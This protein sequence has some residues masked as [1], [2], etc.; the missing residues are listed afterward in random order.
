M[1]TSRAR[2]AL[3]L[4]AALL[5]PARALAQPAPAPTPPAAPAPG[6]PAPD[7]PGT[8][9]GWKSPARAAEPPILPPPSRP[10]PPTSSAGTDVAT[11]EPHAAATVILSD[12][13]SE[14]KEDARVRA[15][16]ARVSA[17]EQRIQ[18]LEGRLAFLKHLRLESFIQ[19][20]LLV[21][22]YN[23]AASPNLQPNGELPIGI[24]ANDTTAKL[25]G[26]TTNGT[27]FRVR[28]ARMRTFYETDVMKMFLQIDV[29]PA[30]GV[31]P[32]IGTILRNAE[33]SGIVRWSRDV[34]TELT[35][36]LFFTPFRAELLEASVNRPFIERTWFIQNV[37]PIER[38]YGAK[39]RTIAL[40]GDRLVVE[41]A[42][43]NGQRLGERNFVALP[44][45]NRSK[46]FIGYVTYRLG[47]VTVGASGYLGRGQLIDAEALRFKQYSR[48]AVNYQASAAYRLLGGIGE[49]RLSS[50][51][52]IARNMDAGV[53]YPFAVPAIP[54][55]FTDDVAHL[56]QR[57]LYVRA[58]QDIKRHVTLG[59]R[60]DMYTP[61]TA[62]KNNARDTHAF[63]A[64]WKVS[65]NLRFMSELGWAI[66]N[67]HPLGAPAPSKHIVYFS[68]VLQAMF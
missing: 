43:V 41:V 11:S 39:A 51:L 9:D 57:A 32:G 62:I 48:W 15:L 20:Q 21:Q 13:E 68:N 18:K 55:R 67:V 65:P 63:L 1:S 64:V 14:A 38:D 25:D 35:A 22:S 36:G 5:A 59:Y 33:A 24:G 12:R 27:F 47:F 3:L 2:F 66:D 52:T 42:A 26:T 50:E 10:D 40:D 4:S 61:N 60:Y 56:D 23:T 29:L 34:R 31:G 53:I 45:L 7:T 46:D 44:D 54:A 19:P 30:G 49:S 8:E 6:E 16:E 37:F 28:R 58:E 17:D